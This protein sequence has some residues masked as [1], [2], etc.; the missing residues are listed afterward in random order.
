M[1]A[2]AFINRSLMT[3]S[4]FWAFFLAVIITID[5][6]G[7]AF[8]GAPL[9]GAV[10]IIV[11]SIVVIAFLQLAYAVGSGSML[12]A[13]FIIGLFPKRGQ[14][15]IDIAGLLTGA[16][17]FLLLAYAVVDP[18]AGA[19]VSGEYEGEGALRVPTWPI[20]STILV[21]SLLAAVNYVVLAVT[22]F[23]REEPANV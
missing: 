7:R 18:L 16:A 4:A 13:D 21:G 14:L 10:E 19:Y 11:N 6:V 20:Y 5:V 9:T 12:R 23:R 8:F 22:R 15:I 17:V 3:L 2:V 1:V